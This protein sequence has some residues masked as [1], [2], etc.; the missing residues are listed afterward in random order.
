MEVVSSFARTLRKAI[1]ASVVPAINWYQLT[2]LVMVSMSHLL[3]EYTDNL[4]Q[5]TSHLLLTGIYQYWSYIDNIDTVDTV[6][7]FSHWLF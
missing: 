3:P 1:I 2:S 7:L 4:K 5:F 6:F